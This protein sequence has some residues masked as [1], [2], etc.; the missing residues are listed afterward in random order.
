MSGI[1]TNLINGV[2]RF[3]LVAIVQLVPRGTSLLLAEEEFILLVT[4]NSVSKWSVHLHGIYIHML[5]YYF[6][7]NNIWSKKP[8]E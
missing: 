1:K 2:I 3:L 8:V 7:D 6:Q 5:R 4:G